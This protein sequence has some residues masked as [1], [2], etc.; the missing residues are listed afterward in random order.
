VVKRQDIGV[1]AAW[2]N[3]QDAKFAKRFFTSPGRPGHLREQSA[4][5]IDALALEAFRP[6]R[7]GLD[8]AP[9]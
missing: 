5:E 9:N 8:A 3:R 2:L 7:G 4:V 6:L 1:I